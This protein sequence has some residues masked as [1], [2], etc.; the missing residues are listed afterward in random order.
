MADSP[1]AGA[2]PDATALQMIEEKQWLAIFGTLTSEEVATLATAINIPDL[3]AASFINSGDILKNT[4]AAISN[5]MTS[6]PT[7][8]EQTSV[9]PYLRINLLVTELAVVNGYNGFFI[10]P[11]LSAVSQFVMSKL[12]N[13]NT[14]QP[15]PAAN[16]EKAQQQQATNSFMKWFFPLFSLFLCASYTASFALYW[17][18]S[19]LI[20]MATTQLINWHLDRKE[21]LEQEA[22][23]SAVANK[24]GLK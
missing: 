9:V 3:S 6:M 5:A 17:V 2:W 14:P 24:G 1:F 10:L 20:G 21:K 8:V 13:T 12:Q 16:D 19:N 22:P 11:V 18:V 7:Y 4:I 23:A 15:T